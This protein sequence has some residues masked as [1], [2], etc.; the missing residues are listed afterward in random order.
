MRTRLISARAVAFSWLLPSVCLRYGIALPSVWLRRR[1]SKLRQFNNFRSDYPLTLNWFWSPNWNVRAKLHMY[2]F[3]V[4]RSD[5]FSSRSKY[6]FEFHRLAC[7]VAYP[8]IDLARRS[9]CREPVATLLASEYA[10]QLSPVPHLDLIAARKFAHQ[11][12]NSSTSVRLHPTTEHRLPLTLVSVGV[13]PIS[14]E[15]T[16]R[17][18]SCIEA[19]EQ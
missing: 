18:R 19:E 6:R 16:E 2:R 4:S 7:V 10:R 5:S 15:L 8:S 14:P 17:K 11:E 3:L 12:R 9:H 1:P 13:I